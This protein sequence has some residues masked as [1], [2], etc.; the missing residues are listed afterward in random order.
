MRRTEPLIP[1]RHP[2]YG[3]CSRHGLAMRPQSL[4]A[5]QGCQA[6]SALRHII[7]RVDPPIRGVAS[8]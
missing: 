7:A 2:A 5:Y 6:P 4:L 1:T 8:P 3:H